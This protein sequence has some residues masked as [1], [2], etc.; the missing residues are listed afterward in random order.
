MALA[1]GQTSDL[2]DHF[3]Q[4]SRL[5]QH[6]TLNDEERYVIT[7]DFRTGRIEEPI[8]TAM[9]SVFS[10]D[11]LVARAALVPL[12][13]LANLEGTRRRDRYEELFTLIE[14]QALAPEVKD[15]AHAVRAADFQETRISALEA[16]LGAVISPARKRYRSFLDMVRKLIDNRVT[17]ATFRD[18]FL[19]F[20][21]SVAGRLDFG[22]Y[23]FCMDRI[24]INPV[25][26]LMAKRFLVE[27]MLKFPPLIR[28]ELLSNLLVHPQ[29]NS[30]VRSFVRQLIVAGLDRK[31]AAEVRLLEKFKRSRQLNIDDFDPMAGR[32]ITTA[33]FANRHPAPA[34]IS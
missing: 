28:R 10:K 8:A 2:A 32:G 5:G 31:A 25:I 11:I 22:I 7:D 21:F 6:L 13:V 18:E 34:G 9:A 30:E 26:P 33:A 23:S 24:F 14:A 3:L 29:G 16:E 12:A 27:E 20:T 4:C 1:N 17:P 19:D 15:A